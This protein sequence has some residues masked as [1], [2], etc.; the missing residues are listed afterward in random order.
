MILF[1]DDLFT[2]NLSIH[3]SPNDISITQKPSHHTEMKGL[4][5]GINA[6][7]EWDPAKV[8]PPCGA[9]YAHSIH[10]NSLQIYILYKYIYLYSYHHMYA[11]IYIHISDN[12]SDS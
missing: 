6:E 2:I 12:W 3:H 9:W 10:N 11:Y 8:S 7:R 1:Y 5:S 4:I